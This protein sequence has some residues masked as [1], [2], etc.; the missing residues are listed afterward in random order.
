MFLK[1]TLA[2][3]MLEYKEGDDTKPPEIKPSRPK[4]ALNI[5]SQER[6][7]GRVTIL[8]KIKEKLEFVFDL[9]PIP[10][11]SCIIAVLIGLSPARGLFFANPNNPTTVPPLFFCTTAITLIGSTVTPMMNIVLGSKLT[12]GPKEGSA[13]IVLIMLTCWLKLVVIPL[14]FGFGLIYVVGVN[15]THWITDPTM[16]F[17]LLLESANPPA[18][19]LL[20]M[21]TAN[22]FM[23]EEMTSLIFYSY[24]MAVFTLTAFSFLFLLLL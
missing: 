22:D 20:L 10:L 18:L 24:I 23:V 16:L 7:K 9:L 3:K 13:N 6:I 8:D 15:I 21:C 5:N 12:K 19:L 17:V 1:W 14:V 4:D 2:D 11:W